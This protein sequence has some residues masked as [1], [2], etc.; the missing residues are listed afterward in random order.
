MLFHVGHIAR[1]SVQVKEKSRKGRAGPYL[2]PAKGCYRLVQGLACLLPWT[3]MPAG[4]L[5]FDNPSIPAGG[6][7]TMDMASFRGECPDLPPPCGTVVRHTVDPDAFQEMITGMQPPEKRCVDM[8]VT[9]WC[10][11]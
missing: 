9:T 5:P 2:V 1:E 4:S 3:Q 10:R 6:R 8:R 11:P 7:F